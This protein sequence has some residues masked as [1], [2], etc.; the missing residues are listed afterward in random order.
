[1]DLPYLKRAWK[2]I[3]Q[4]DENDVPWIFLWKMKDLAC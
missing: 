2:E 4:S 1:M 3:K